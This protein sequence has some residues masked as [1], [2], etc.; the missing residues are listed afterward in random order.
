MK[1]VLSF[2]SLCLLLVVVAAAGLDPF[3]RPPEIPYAGFYNEAVSDAHMSRFSH[4]AGPFLPQAQELIKHFDECPHDDYLFLD[5]YGQGTYG[6]VYK[7]LHY[8]TGRVVAVKVFDLLRSLDSMPTLDPS[9]SFNIFLRSAI[10]ELY[11][12]WLAKSPHSVS[13]Y[14]SYIYRYY[15][16]VVFEAGELGSLNTVLDNNTRPLS[17]GILANICKKMV[18]AVAAVHAKDVLHLDVGVNNC[19]LSPDETNMDV[20]LKLI[21]FGLSEKYS[22]SPVFLQAGAPCFGAPECRPGHP[23]VSKYAHS[24]ASDVYS[25][26]ATL[27]YL[28]AGGPDRYTIYDTD[29]GY[30]IHDFSKI[31]QIRGCSPTFRA[32]IEGCTAED[33]RLRWSLQDILNSQ[34][35]KD[36]PFEPILSENCIS[37]LLA[38]DREEVAAFRLL[39]CR[40]DGPLPEDMLPTFSVNEER[41]LALQKEF[42]APLQSY[43]KLLGACLL[44]TPF[45]LSP[46]LSTKFTKKFEVE[47]LGRLKSLFYFLSVIF[48]QKI[49]IVVQ[50]LPFFDLMLLLLFSASVAYASLLLLRDCCVSL[51]LVVF[52]LCFTL[53]AYSYSV[54]PHTF[55]YKVAHAAFSFKPTMFDV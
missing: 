21:D 51:F 36:T 2:A 44:L 12:S 4:L 31:F 50:D 26:A 3:D 53:L 25:I 34:F 42:T 54:V 13:I 27:V 35:I 41:Q 7:A 28:F 19:V 47:S 29:K 18:E 49:L 15:V 39:T 43:Q 23:N 16:C 6:V 17:M 52:P 38:Q 9:V 8:R 11:F 48:L 5:S 45:L 46:C 10:N 32:L 37:A 1:I 40:L 20:L 33:P 55:C 14:D 22:D 30:F 24:P